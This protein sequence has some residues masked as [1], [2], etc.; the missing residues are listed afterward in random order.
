MNACGV[1]WVQCTPVPS[2]VD[3]YLYVGQRVQLGCHPHGGTPAIMGYAPLGVMFPPLESFLSALGYTP[4][5][6]VQPLPGYANLGVG[7]EGKFSVAASEV[8]N[9]CTVF[10]FFQDLPYNCEVSGGWV[11]AAL[12]LLVQGWSTGGII[13]GDMWWILTVYHKQLPV[14]L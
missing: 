2:E 3:S 6:T 14:H 10:Y 7:K 4:L 12:Y 13:Y 8:G 1:R 5:E 11:A 9:N